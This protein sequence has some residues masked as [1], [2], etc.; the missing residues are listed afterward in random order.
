MKASSCRSALCELALLEATAGRSTDRL[1]AAVE[2]F[3][4]HEPEVRGTRK[5]FE[6]YFAVGPL[7]DA[8]HYYFGHYYTARALHRLPAADQK[9]LSAK[10]RDV[11]L[12]QVELD[13]SFVDAQMQGKSYSTAMALLTLLE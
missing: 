12:S 9:R 4:T 11:I 7:H 1:R 13:G 3:F 10:Q 5:I 8:Y 2:L 6:S